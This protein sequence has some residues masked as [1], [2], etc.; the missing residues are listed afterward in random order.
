MSIK[1]AERKKIM[2]EL[3]R[4]DILDSAVDL[5]LEKGIKKLTMD[6]VASGAGIAKGTVYLYYKD[7]KV[8]LDS[9]VSYYFKPLEEEYKN[10][11]DSNLDPIL[12]LEQIARKS[13]EYVDK[14][15]Q[16]F[17]EVRNVMFSTTDQYIE[18]ENSWY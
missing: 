17:K 4:K 16:L 15:I 14:N 18:N 7:K 8:L 3:T 1:K 9:V 10:I 13:L 5:L 12:K 11:S 2:E 6:K